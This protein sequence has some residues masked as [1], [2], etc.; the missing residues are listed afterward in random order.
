MLTITSLYVIFI[1]LTVFYLYKKSN[2]HLK[3]KDL[4][5]VFFEFEKEEN[6]YSTMTDQERLIYDCLKQW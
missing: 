4:K 5:M 2:S 6:Q 1:S 3:K